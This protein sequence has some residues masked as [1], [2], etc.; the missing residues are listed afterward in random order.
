MAI[1]IPRIVLSSWIKLDLKSTLPLDF[2][3]TWINN[4]SNSFY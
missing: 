3:I 2:S 1:W 4:S